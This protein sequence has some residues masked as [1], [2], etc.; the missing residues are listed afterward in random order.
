MDARRPS[1][2]RVATIPIVVW[3]PTHGRVA[4]MGEQMFRSDF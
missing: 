4:T 1:H 2:G 3:R